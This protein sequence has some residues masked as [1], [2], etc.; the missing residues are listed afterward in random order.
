[1]VLC[2]VAQAGLEFVIFQ[3]STS[4]MIAFQVLSYHT[5][6]FTVFLNFHNSQFSFYKTFIKEMGPGYEKRMM[7]LVLN[8]MSVVKTSA[9]PECL[10]CSRHTVSQRPSHVCRNSVNAHLNASH[11]YKWSLQDQPIRC[12][13]RYK[14]WSEI[15]YLWHLIQAKWLFWK[16]CQPLW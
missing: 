15:V 5:H 2:H 9:F 8:I 12:W 6:N 13:F 10:L 7:S 16:L 3:A 4:Q 1:M 11:A 14:I